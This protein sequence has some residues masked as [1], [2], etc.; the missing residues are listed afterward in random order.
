MD[1]I[2]MYQA[3]FDNA[4]ASLGTAF[5]IQQAMLLKR[6][7][8]HVYLAYDSDGAGVAAAQKAIPLLREVGISARVINMQPHKDP[9]EFIK[10]LGAEAFEERIRQAESSMMFQ[11]RIASE[12]YDQQDPEERTKFQ[13]E[14]VKLVSVIQDPLERD[15][16]LEA[17]ANR[18]FI[19]K[20][21]L[22]ESDNRYGAYRTEQ[23]RYQELLERET[24][25]DVRRQERREER[26]QQPQR[27]LLGWLVA[28]PDQLFPQMKGRIG[29][30]DFTDA[31]YRELAQRL[32]EQYEA[33]GSLNPAAIIQQYEDL[34]AETKADGAVPGGPCDGHHGS[35]TEGKRG[36]SSISVGTF[37]GYFKTTGYYPAKRSDSDM[38]Y[39]S[40]L[41]LKY[42]YKWK[43]GKPWKEKMKK[44]IWT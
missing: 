14:V 18:Y 12:Q 36:K 8:D 19:D 2:A 9:D 40:D 37:A 30:E 22:T 23:N 38:E 1:V 42:D 39:F 41:W 3:G 13:Q 6:Y 35:G 16:Y 5:T 28:Y 43:D 17:I 10:T 44:R 29:P 4:A 24:P 15:N 32:F 33:T 11:V 31:F 21:N 27:L 20:K 34:E 26:K 25:Q 7:T